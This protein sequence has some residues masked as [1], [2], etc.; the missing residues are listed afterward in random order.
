MP[1]TKTKSI[2]IHATPELVFAYMDNIGN[3]GMHMTKNSMPMMGSKLEL[4]QLSENTSGL[5][6][7]F[8]WYGQMLGFTLDFTV[9][10]TK[11]IK[12]REK[13]WE[14][15]G[16]AK[17]IILQW[18]RMHLVVLPEGQYTRAELSIVY[19]KPT[20]PI[21]R[22]IALFLAPMYANW[23]LNNMLNDSKNSLEK[24]SLSDAGA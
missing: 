11:W 24:P 15:V 2:I 10:V 21:F 3:A 17:M 16:E 4:K 1:V 9:V 7:K 20:N 12:N 23:C 19:T 8:R 14:T 22:I 13:V 5:N 6:S 18:Y